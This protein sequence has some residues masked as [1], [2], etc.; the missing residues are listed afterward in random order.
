MKINNVS[1]SVSLIRLT[2]S[3]NI[4][5][6][7]YLAIIIF[8][9]STELLQMSFDNNG[10]LIKLFIIF[11]SLT[12]FYFLIIV[13]FKVKNRKKVL[14]SA[15]SDLSLKYVDFLQDRIDFCFVD[16]KYN[17][18]CGY[19]DI[20]NFEMELYTILL[21]NKVSGIYYKIHEIELN[22]TLLNGKEFSLKNAPFKPMTLVYKIID[23]TR[24]VKDFSYKFSGA[25]KCEDIKEMIDDYRKKGCK[26]V[27]SNKTETD[28]KDASAVTFV[29]GLLALVA[30]FGDVIKIINE[31]YCSEI[32]LLFLSA[33]FTFFSIV[34]DIFIVWDKINDKIFG[35]EHKSNE[36][37]ER[38]PFIILSI[39]IIIFALLIFI[40]FKP[41]F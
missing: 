10:L 27:L 8:M 32:F 19:E 4:R 26:Q 22:F 34:L 31:G 3:Y 40:L 39:K 28:F 23:Y 20:E 1:K 30:S 33:L 13:I 11:L 18:S 21:C 9:A 29:I 37:I 24:G 16:P 36:L 12:I 5:L 35:K 25:G 38:F 6:L 14:K 17:I 15:N 7:G 41:L 2:N